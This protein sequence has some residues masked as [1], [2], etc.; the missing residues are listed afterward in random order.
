MAAQPVRRLA[1][2][3]RPG[4]TRTGQNKDRHGSRDGHPAPPFRQLGEVVGPHQP[5]EFL[6]RKELPEPSHRIGGIDGAE[7]A[8]DVRGDDP[9]PIG[10]FTRGGKAFGEWRHAVIW[11]QRVAGGDHQP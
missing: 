11:F 2:K 4:L 8:L 3:G 10:D 6:S 1:G 9:P 7:P 5:Y